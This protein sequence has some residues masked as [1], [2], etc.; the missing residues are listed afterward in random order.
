MT[1]TLVLLGL[2][3]TLHVWPDLP[4]SRWLAGMVIEAPARLLGRVRPGQ[5]AMMELGVA[6]L[7]LAIWFEIDEIRMLA[8]AAAPMGDLVMLASAI[9]WGGVAELV[10]AAVLSSSMLARWPVFGRWAGRMSA[11]RNARPRRVERPANDSDDGEGRRLA[12]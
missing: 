10:M 1:A 8:A 6:L 2:T 4:V 7:G 5:W 9:E 12:A 3:L 11:S